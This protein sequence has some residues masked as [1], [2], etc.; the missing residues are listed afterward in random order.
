MA[1]WNQ[2]GLVPGLLD[3]GGILAFRCNGTSTM[4]CRRYAG[5][6]PNEVVLTITDYRY[7]PKDEKGFC[8]QHVREAL[9]SYLTEMEEIDSGP[10][11]DES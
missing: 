8:L 11:E 3:Q 9:A 5:T 1:V 10:P 6:C 7:T 4:N 2:E